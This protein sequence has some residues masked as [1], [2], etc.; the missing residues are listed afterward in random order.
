MV[1]WLAAAA[2]FLLCFRAE[3]AQLLV[4]SPPTYSADVVNS[5]P[6]DTGAFTQGLQLDPNGATL[7]ESTGLY[8]ESTVR[9]VELASGRVLQCEHLPSSWFG[10]GI[11]VQAGRCIQLLWREGIILVRDPSSLKLRDTVPLP[12][13]IAEGWGI[14]G[15]GQQSLFVS[16]GSSTLH[17]LDDRTFNVKR[18]LRVR[19]GPRELPALNDLQWVNG[20]IWANLWHEEKLAVI[21]PADGSVRCFVDLRRLL[22]PEERRQLG[23]S[24]AMRAEAVLNGLAYDPQAS[25]LFVTGKC[26]PRI[27]EIDT[28]ALRDSPSSST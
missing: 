14:T 26:W 18:R 3:P 24:P 4:L 6:H 5:F 16:D 2:I 13:G 19:A 27:F 1:R 28:D 23:G 15:D 21:N 11:A 12:S 8:G 25:R 9:R 7:I 10:E 22:K 20:E 17:E